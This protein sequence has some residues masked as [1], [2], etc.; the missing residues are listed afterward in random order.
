[1]RLG[2]TAA[3]TGIQTVAPAMAA[4]GGGSILLTGGGLP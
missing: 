1:L 3:L 4:G 2:L